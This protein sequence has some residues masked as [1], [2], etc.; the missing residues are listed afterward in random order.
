MISVFRG[1]Q[2]FLLDFLNFTCKQFEFFPGKTEKESQSKLEVYHLKYSNRPFQIALKQFLLF[3]TDQQL[4]MGKNRKQ[5]QFQKRH[6]IK[7]SIFFHLSLFPD[8]QSSS[9][10]PSKLSINFR[11]QY[12]NSLNLNF[13]FLK[14]IPVIAKRIR[15]P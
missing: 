14:I 8:Q 9:L 2:I 15:I 13:T 7:N 4:S 10:M 12:I 3:A 1:Q 6:Q 11:S 5:F